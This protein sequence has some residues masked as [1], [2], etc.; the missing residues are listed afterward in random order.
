MRSRWSMF[1]LVV[2]VWLAY[3]P[4]AHAQERAAL[5][6]D[7]IKSAEVELAARDVIGQRG[8]AV[9]DRQ[10]V[11]AARQFMGDNTLDEAGLRGLGKQVGA[12][13]VIQIATKRSHDGKLAVRI[14]IVTQT[15][16][17]TRFTMT[18]KSDLS[19]EVGRLLGE[20]M[21]EL[22][23]AG[24][25]S[26]PATATPTPTPQT[27][28]PSTTPAPNTT[29]APPPTNR[30]PNAAAG[31]GN[32]QAAAPTAA[33]VSPEVVPGLKPPPT[34]KPIPLA[35]PRVPFQNIN[36]F[37]AGLAKFPAV[38]AWAAGMLDFRLDLITVDTP[39]ATDTSVD[40]NVLGD[41]NFGAGYRFSPGVPF[42]LNAFSRTIFNGDGSSTI[43]GVGGSYNDITFGC[44]LFGNHGFDI[45][46]YLICQYGLV[47][48]IR[49]I[50]PDWAHGLAIFGS[51]GIDYNFVDTNVITLSVGWGAVYGS[52]HQRSGPINGYRYKVWKYQGKHPN[53]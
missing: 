35:D 37:K 2:V 32:P 40:F 50:T 44:G 34:L 27:P 28:A 3:S 8:I 42:A 24:G 14:L 51:F 41:L 23:Q 15:K 4:Q 43:F 46:H 21:S 30:Q 45:S 31:T 48:P 26:T 19:A 6:L 9:V 12:T 53:G 25:S 5:V 39:L 7:G 33:V 1:G 18:G 10:S 36:V 29:P 11:E 38:T 17:A 22:D 47:I 52:L 13:M 49:N 16:D 20:A